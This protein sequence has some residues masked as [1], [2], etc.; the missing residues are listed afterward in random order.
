[1]GTTDYIAQPTPGI[2]V[3]PDLTDTLA[4]HLPPIQAPTSENLLEDRTHAEPART[5]G[6]VDYAPV[7]DEDRRLLNG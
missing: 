6:P 2:A 7:S 3:T 4:V 5:V 1:M